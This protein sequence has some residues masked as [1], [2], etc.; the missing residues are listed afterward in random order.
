MESMDV[1]Q[2]GTSAATTPAAE[3]GEI[4][5][6]L[7]LKLNAGFWP[8]CLKNVI[9]A[10]TFPAVSSWCFHLSRRPGQERDR[11]GD[12]LAG[13]LLRLLRTLRHS[14]GDAKRRSQDPH[15]QK[16]HVPQ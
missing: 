8:L 13:L 11:G 3:N 5:R 2:E 10:S 16:C 1:A 6:F 12:D 15:L 14:R 9:D 4:I 7:S